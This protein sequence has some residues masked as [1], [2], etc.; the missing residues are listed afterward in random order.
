MGKE[1]NVKVAHVHWSWIYGWYWWPKM[2][3]QQTQG[4]NPVDAVCRHWAWLRFHWDV[5]L[6]A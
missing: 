4:L 5:W 3:F 6:Y 1:G 2:Y